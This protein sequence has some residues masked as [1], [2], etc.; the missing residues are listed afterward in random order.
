MIKGY[1]LQFAGRFILSDPE[2]SARIEPGLALA[3]RRSEPELKPTGWYPRH[4][5]VK[6]WRT[7]AD[8]QPDESSAYDALVR[9]GTSVGTQATNTFL[10]L[11][12]KVLTPKLFAGKF[13]DFFARDHQNGGAAAVEEIAPN[14]VVLVVR[15]IEGYDHFGPN[16]VGW[17]GVGF[18]AMVKNPKIVCSP[19][20]LAA[21]G[22]KELRVTATWE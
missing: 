5:L 18:R 13:P 22:P 20:S 7:I 11:L 12:F 2:I 9:C 4:D 16:T 10:K 19:W 8:T 14:R 3:I 21:P 6:L 15:D 17:A 1:I